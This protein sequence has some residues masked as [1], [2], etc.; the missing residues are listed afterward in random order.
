MSRAREAG[1]L[2]S[3]FVAAYWL[4][5]GRQRAF[6]DGRRWGHMEGTLRTNRDVRRGQG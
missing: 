5:T 6:E 1:W 3:L 2:V 4:L